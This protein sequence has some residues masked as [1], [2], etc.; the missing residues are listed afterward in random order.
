MCF[1]TICLDTSDYFSSLSNPWKYCNIN[2]WPDQPRLSQALSHH[3]L[4]IQ[5]NRKG[6]L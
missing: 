1:V 3:Q 5:E 2:L 6:H 4:A